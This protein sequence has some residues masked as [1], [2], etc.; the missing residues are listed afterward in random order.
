MPLPEGTRY[1]WIVRGGKK[2]RLAF[3][4]GTNKVIE[5]K[6][7]G[8]TAHKVGNPHPDKELRHSV[9]KQR[10]AKLKKKKKS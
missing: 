10:A 1:R 6:K 8:G 3:K 2:I 5:V 7:K 9:M 4:G